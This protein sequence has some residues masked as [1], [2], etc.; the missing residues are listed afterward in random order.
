VSVASNKGDGGGP[1]KYSQ[2]EPEPTV[3]VHENFV[4]YKVS[5]LPQL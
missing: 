5:G 3:V 4:V 2:A 1:S